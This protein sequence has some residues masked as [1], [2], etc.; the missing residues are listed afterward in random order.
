[1]RVFS[2]LTATCLAVALVASPIAFAGPDEELKGAPTPARMDG[3]EP[4]TYRYGLLLRTATAVDPEACEQACTAENACSSWSLISFEPETAPRCELKRNIGPAI[5]RPGAVSGIAVKF[6]PV[7]VAPPETSD[8]PDAPS[9]KGKPTKPAKPSKTRASTQTTGSS[10]AAP[11]IYRP[12]GSNLD[13]G[14]L[15]SS[16]TTITAGKNGAPVVI[17]PNN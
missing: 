6:H 13:G 7:A 3:H 11:V 12:G 2:Y 1:M 14:P 17:K 16:R 8:L 15:T 9:L 5:S 10:N 4:N